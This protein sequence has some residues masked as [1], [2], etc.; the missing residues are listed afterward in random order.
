MELVELA[1]PAA[2][3]LGCE[4]EL[5]GIE[6]LCARGSGAEEQRRVHEEEGSL[7][8]VAQWL[9]QQTVAGL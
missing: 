1:L 4:A 9:A 7:L 6:H 2:Q 8:A 5:D 3:R